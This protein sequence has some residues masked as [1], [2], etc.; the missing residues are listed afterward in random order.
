MWW[1]ARGA[2]YPDPQDWLT[3]QFDKGAPNN[4]WNYGQNISTNASTQQATQQQMEQADTTRDTT[5]R[6]SLYN[7]AEQQVVHDI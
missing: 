7:Q 3:L 5:A 6:M 1:L 4:N 2:D